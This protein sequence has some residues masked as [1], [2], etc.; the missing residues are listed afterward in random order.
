MNHRSQ[1]SAFSLIEVTLALGVAAVALIA[2]FGLLVTGAQTSHTAME[3]S[4]SS[5]ILTAV[6][7]DLRATP[8]TSPPGQAAT[9]LQYKINIPANPV[10]AATN[11]TL[12]FTSEGECSTSLS[13]FT[14]CDLSAPIPSPAPP[15][16][17]RYRLTVTFSPNG[18]GTR[19][20]T[21]VDLKMTWPAA[22]NPA[23]VNTSSAEAFVALDRN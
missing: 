14:P 17:V 21:F 10:A 3:Q 20:A 15:L 7:A 4:A 23:N 1:A 9:S 11:S 5:D 16:Q 22:A 18:S 13:S 12:Y 6:A 2:I 8:K 19:T